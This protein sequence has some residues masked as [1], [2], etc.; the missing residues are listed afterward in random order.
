MAADEQIFV[1]FPHFQW[2]KKAV[3]GRQ[4]RQYW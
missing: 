2:D 3:F 1:L 4:G